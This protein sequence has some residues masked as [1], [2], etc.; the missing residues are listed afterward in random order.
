MKKK[1]LSMEEIKTKELEIL[2]YIDNFWQKKFYR[3]FYKL[4]NLIRSCKTQRIYSLG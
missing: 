2:K 3:I 1:Y 4:R